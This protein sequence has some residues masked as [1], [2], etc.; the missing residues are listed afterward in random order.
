LLN[1]AARYFPILR[2]LQQYIDDHALI[3]EIGSGPVGIGEFRKE[4]FIGSDICF[5]WPPQH[6]M[7]PVRC[8]ASCLPFRDGSFDAVV[9]SD[10][11]E[12]VP[13]ASRA[14]VVREALRVSRKVAIFAFPCG[15]RAH[16][17]DEGLLD[18]YHRKNLPIPSWLSEHMENPFPE[19][20]L[21]GDVGP[22]WRVKSFANES[23]AFHSWMMRAE[24]IRVLDY[25]FRVLLLLIPG[26]IESLLKR[27]DS[28]PSYRMI[29]VLAR[30]S[31]FTSGP[32]IDDAANRNYSYV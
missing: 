3:L 16:A 18:E 30:T 6:P 27:A 10:V 1:H 4:S 17:L 5:P 2:E 32:L 9:A 25:S 21:F 11:M 26:A 29:F 13:I 31:G 7:R 12:H 19:D 14:V 28:L 20:S 8:S 23:L 24:M 22:E 15:S